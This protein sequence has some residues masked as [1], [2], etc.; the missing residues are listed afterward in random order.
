MTTMIILIVAGLIIIGC[1]AMV[2]LA[3][4]RMLNDKLPKRARIMKAC[5]TIFALMA[6]GFTKESATEYAVRDIGINTKEDLDELIA[7]CAVFQ[8]KAL[9][10]KKSLEYRRESA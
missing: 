9:K 10:H 7:A 2:I 4:I 8:E 1:L 3:R 5:A 6:Q